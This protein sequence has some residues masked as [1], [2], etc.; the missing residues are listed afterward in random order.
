MPSPARVIPPRGAYSGTT[1]YGN[2]PQGLTVSRPGN[3]TARPNWA[4]THSFWL[5]PG[6]THSRYET[7]TRGVP[8]LS[9][10]VH[11]SVTR[12]AHAAA[13]T[14]PT[15][16]PAT[17]CR[18]PPYARSRCRGHRADRRGAPTGARSPSGHR[19]RPVIARRNA[20]PAGQSLPSLDQGVTAG[21][22]DAGCRAVRCWNWPPRGMRGRIQ[23]TGEEA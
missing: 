19:F 9:P 10:S 17:R 20:L 18:T 6:K 4:V 8:V 13:G 22:P 14:T 5:L 12:R 16:S 11:C 21:L 7:F 3:R 1:Q 2:W 23:R 15:G